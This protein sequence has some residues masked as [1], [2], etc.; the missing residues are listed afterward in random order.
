MSEIAKQPVR[1]R[2]VP[3][4]ASQPREPIQSQFSVGVTL[5]LVVPLLALGLRLASEQTAN[6][7]F[8][9]LAG[10][11]LLGRAHAIRAL[12]LAWLITMINPGFAPEA[13]LAPVGRYLVIFAAAA[14][15]FARSEFL[16]RGRVRLIMALTFGLGAF[17]VLHSMIVSPMLD[18]SLLKTI[19]WTVVVLALFGAWMGLAPAEREA[20]SKQLFVGLVLVALLSLPLVLFPEGY[21]RNGT[22]FQGALNHPQAFGSAMALLGAWSVGRLLGEK[23]PSWFLLG[24][25][26]L[27]L[28]LV[29]LSEARTGGL[30]LVFGVTVAALVVP[31]LA[32]KRVSSVLPGL[33]SRRFQVVAFVALAA[34]IVMGSFLV[35]VAE[36]FIAKSGRANVTGLMEAYE[37][38]RGGL[39]DT[40]TDNIRRDPWRGIGFGVASDPYLMT[41]TRD[42]VLG[43]PVGAAIEKGVMPLAVL[44]EGGI[45]GFVLV[46]FWMWTVLR[47]SA[48]GGIAPL[49]VVITILLVNMGEAVLFSPGGMG[50]LQLILVG[51]AISTS[52]EK[53][54]IHPSSGSSHTTTGN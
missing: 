7:S 33:K 44:E 6:L 17:F 8:Y 39:M 34:A 41:I 35:S 43:L 2:S 4:S 49:A 37:V 53:K 19:S 1:R 40:M 47:L 27:C 24:V 42:P 14:A 32:G 3:W 30:A 26:A 16:S 51:W 46:A 5:L 22:G 28:V 13:T 12:A 10:Y 20:L 36:E 52:F 11:A 21:L 29:V 25:A 48:R 15:V 45:L 9:L 23:R 50:L 31:F 38:S 18:V 54:G